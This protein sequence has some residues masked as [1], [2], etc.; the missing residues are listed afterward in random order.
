MDE[1]VPTL[2]GRCRLAWASVR[3]HGL[4]S[5]GS[6]IMGQEI[7]ETS[8]EVL[9]RMGGHIYEKEKEAETF[10]ELAKIRNTL[11]HRYLDLKWNDIKRFLEIAPLLYPS[12][13]NFIKRQIGKER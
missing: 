11:A 13:L 7:P 3:Y 8:R 6:T 5:R 1:C 10:S 9:F 12:F 4:C 2:D